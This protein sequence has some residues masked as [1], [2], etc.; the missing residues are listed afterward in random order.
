VAQDPSQYSTWVKAREAERTRSRSGSRALT[1]LKI[2]LL[3]TGEPSE[4]LV[5]TLGALQR[6]SDDDW[7]LTAIIEEGW[8]IRFTTLLAVSGLQRLA[9]RVRVLQAPASSSLQQKFT[10]ALANITGSVAILFPGDIWAAD[11]VRQLA[12]ALIPG[13][14]VYA[15]EDHVEN[16]DHTDPRL[17]PGFSPDFLLHSPYVGRPMAISAETLEALPPEGTKDDLQFEHDLSLRASECALAVVH[18]AE[19]LCHRTTATPS[20]G[21]H[22]CDHIAAALARRSETGSVVPS[23][24]TGVTNIQRQLLSGTS[25]TIIIPFRDAPRLLRTCV[26]SIES[27][28]DEVR[29]DFVLIDNDSEEPETETLVDRLGSR[30][31]VRVIKDSRPF[32]WAQLNN[33]GARLATSDVLIFLNNDIEARRSGW[34]SALCTQA[35][36]PDVAAV[37][38]RLLYPH[39]RV[40]HCGVVI[41]LGGAAGHVLVGTDEINPGYLNMAVATRECAAVTGACFATRREVFESMGGFDESL[42]VDLNDIDFCLRAQRAG[43]RVIFESGAE[44]IHHESPSRGTAGDVADIVRFIHRWEDSIRQGDPYLHWA[45]TRRDASCAIRADDEATWWQNWQA[46]LS[47]SQ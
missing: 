39:G 12:D 13:S 16:G 46:S 15:D 36:R 7:T 11:T 40:Q 23:R 4:D 37:G 26:D 14:M 2:L 21:E 1:S 33:Q 32:N 25:A 44:L 18:I 42:G 22:T 17:K 24:H 35:L 30:P 8:A 10:L 27:T 34:M 47:R 45:L 28:S 29:F 41:G 19:V 3:V 31:N 43:L 20:G 5:Q 6:Q 38:A 9:K